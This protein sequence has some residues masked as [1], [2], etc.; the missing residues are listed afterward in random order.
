[1]LVLAGF[2]GVLAGCDGE[3]S[4][5]TAAETAGETTGEATTAP[6][7]STPTTAD[8]TTGGADGNYTAFHQIGTGQYTRLYVRM[9]DPEAGLC[10]TATFTYPLDEGEDGYTISVPAMWVTEYGLVQQTGAECLTTLQIEA[11]PVAGTGGT[12]TATWSTE[13]ACPPTVD[14]D[15]VLTF[16]P[17]YPWVPSE[18]VAMKAD[19]VAVQGC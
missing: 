9:W 14:I 5:E 4:D 13:D 19:G 12:G 11:E 1:M 17:D 6:T 18:P 15:V 3:G 10:T 2:C 16:P 8:G 7:S